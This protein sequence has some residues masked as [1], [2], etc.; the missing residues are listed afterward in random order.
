MREKTQAHRKLEDN[1]PEDIKLARTTKMSNLSHRIAKKLND[2]L[3]GTEQLVLI[4]G[5]SICKL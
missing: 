1:V 2:R 4:E 5:V 3:I